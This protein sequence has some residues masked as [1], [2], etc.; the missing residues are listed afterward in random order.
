[1]PLPS[2][3]NLLRVHVEL[4]QKDFEDLVVGMHVWGEAERGD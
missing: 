2:F 3:G 1:M 4:V